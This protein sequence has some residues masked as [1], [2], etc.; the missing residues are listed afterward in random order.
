MENLELQF[1]RSYG[2]FMI[3]DPI[4]KYLSL[5]HVV[6]YYSEDP[7]EYNSY[8]FYESKVILWVNDKGKIETIRCE[9]ECYWCSK[10]LIGLPFDDFLIL[11]G[12]QPD[13]EESYYV[14]I[15]E[16]KVQKQKV[17]TFDSWSLQVWVWRKRIVTIL[18]SNYDLLDENE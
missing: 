16:N 2:N 9:I 11:A 17:Y 18:I 15:A 10:N 6:E 3:G 12:R 4:S 14:Y 7:N 1:N 13:E 5:P 8:N